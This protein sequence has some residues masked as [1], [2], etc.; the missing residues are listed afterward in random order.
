MREDA[1]G[2][3]RERPHPGSSS[4]AASRRMKAVRS[5]GTKGELALRRVLH[6]AG[7][8]YRVQYPVA[9]RPGRTVDIAFTRSRVAVFVDGCFWH[10]CPLHGTQAKLNSVWWRDKLARNERRD[11]DTNE[12][13]AS[14]G[15]TVIRIW[16]HVPTDEAARI[17][18]DA[19]VHGDERSLSDAADADRVTRAPSGGVCRD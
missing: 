7:L 10:G 1:E 15:W 14:L 4:A 11:A 8:R 19:L 2:S 13:L 5:R 16:E 3:T 6:G 12:H 9:G 17:V 18:I